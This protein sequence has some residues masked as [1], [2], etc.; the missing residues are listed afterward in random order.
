MAVHQT[1]YC[2]FHE[3]GPVDGK[4]KLSLVSLLQGGFF[5]GCWILF[6]LFGFVLFSSSP[7]RSLSLGK[8]SL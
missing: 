8:L 5:F 1:S 6:Y 3:L 7:Q 2:F 4:G